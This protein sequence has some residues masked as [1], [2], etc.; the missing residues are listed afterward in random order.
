M[1]MAHRP[2]SSIALRRFNI[3]EHGAVRTTGDAS[4]ADGKWVGFEV[5]F[6]EHGL[7]DMGKEWIQYG[8][9]N[10]R[11]AAPPAEAGGMSRPS[12][13]AAHRSFTP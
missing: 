11:L 10:D 7:F 12:G 3:C 13:G 4:G 6:F 1:K 8:D 5:F 9:I 2:G